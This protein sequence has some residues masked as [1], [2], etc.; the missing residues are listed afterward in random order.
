MGQ[1]QF[2]FFSCDPGMEVGRS[3]V[4]VVI[5]WV[6]NMKQKLHFYFLC[7]ELTTFKKLLK[8]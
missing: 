1:Y 5:N 6:I 2:F 7:D 8:I 3:A 4:A